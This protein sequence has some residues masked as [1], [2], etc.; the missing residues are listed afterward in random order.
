MIYPLALKVAS[1]TIIFRRI[2]NVNGFYKYS[3][4]HLETIMPSKTKKQAKFMAICAHSDNPPASCP[5]KKVAKDFNKH[6]KET[7]I[8]KKEGEDKDQEFP[9]LKEMQEKIRERMARRRRKARRAPDD[10]DRPDSDF[11]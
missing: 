10:A 11:L 1:H 7:G 3:I 5:S 6:D 9:M 8:L 4:G 2:S